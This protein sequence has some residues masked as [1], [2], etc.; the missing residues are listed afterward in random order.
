MQ[1]SYCAHQKVWHISNHKVLDQCLPLPPLTWLSAD[2]SHGHSAFGDSTWEQNHK[3]LVRLCLAKRRSACSIHVAVKDRMFYSWTPFQ[4]TYMQH[5]FF[6]ASSGAR[7]FFPF[8]NCGEQGCNDQWHKPVFSTDW[9]YFPSI[10]SV[11]ELF[12][13]FNFRGILICFQ[14]G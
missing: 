6:I 7:H 8:L 10:Y 11:V 9:L 4:C 1:V 2:F 5:P 14:H 12:D 3:V 13:I